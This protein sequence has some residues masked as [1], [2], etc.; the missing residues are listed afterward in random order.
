[1]IEA[2][3]KNIAMSFHDKLLNYGVAFFPQLQPQCSGFQ[4]WHVLIYRYFLF[5]Y[6]REAHMSESNSAHFAQAAPSPDVSSGAGV[7]WGL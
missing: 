7:I 4:F 1:M 5:C 6:K 3:E 2:W